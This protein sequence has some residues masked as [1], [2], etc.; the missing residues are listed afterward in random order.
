MERAM[1]L[2]ACTVWRPGQ[3]VVAYRPVRSMWSVRNAI[4][5]GI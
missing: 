5:D 2:V 1:L 4:C 3:T